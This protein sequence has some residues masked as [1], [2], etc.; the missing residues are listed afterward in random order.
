MLVVGEEAEHVPQFVADVT[1][2]L[3]LDRVDLDS[4]GFV[5]LAT[6]SLFATALT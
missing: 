3:Q 6:A 2:I 5:S 1:P 4:R